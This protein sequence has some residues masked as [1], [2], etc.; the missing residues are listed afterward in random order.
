MPIL[1]LLSTDRVLHQF[2]GCSK[3]RTLELTAQLIAQ[4]QPN[5]DQEAL[6]TGLIGRERLGSTGIGEG[7]AIPHCR[8]AGI[9]EPVGVC[10]QLKNPI[11]FDA[12]DRQPVDLL[13]VL[14]VPEE[15]C[16]QHLATLARLAELFSQPQHRQA[17]RDCENSQQIIDTLAASVTTLSQ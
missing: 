9:S 13:F 7:V 8:V 14:V 4:S 15:Q 5:L 3:K 16:D 6:F 2:D 1:N 10:L 11:D 12:I 17:L